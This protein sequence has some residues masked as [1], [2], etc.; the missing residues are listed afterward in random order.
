MVGRRS[1]LPLQGLPAGLRETRTPTCRAGRGHSDNN[2][3]DRRTPQRLTGS[4][5]RALQRGWQRDTAKASGGSPGGCWGTQGRID[6]PGGH[7]AE[8]AGPSS[9]ASRRCR[10]ALRRAGS[11]T[12]LPP[13]SPAQAPHRYA[14]RP[15][16]R[17]KG[18]KLE[19]AALLIGPP[20]WSYS[21][22]DSAKDAKEPSRVFGV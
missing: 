3:K 2:W 10:N 16:R 12:R 14:R 22:Q 4:P 18:T 6:S 19:N 9:V 11:A 1:L 13:R 20:D 17:V 7:A 5:Q 21:E 8:S 15:F